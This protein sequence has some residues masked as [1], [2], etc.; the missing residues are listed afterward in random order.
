MVAPFAITL[1]LARG[2]GGANG[3]LRGAA[4]RSSNAHMARPESL[5]A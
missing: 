5:S 2:G 1:A 3:E 4:F